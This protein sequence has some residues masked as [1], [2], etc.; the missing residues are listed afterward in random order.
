MPPDKAPGP[1]GFNGVFFKVCWNIIAKYFYELINDFYHK[2]VNLQSINSSFITL[3]S[4]CENL[5]E[6][7]YFRPN[8]LLNCTI[9]IITKLL[10]NR[11]QKV[12]LELVHTN[13]Y[14]FLRSR[15]IQDCLAWAFEYI[16]QCQKLNQDIVI[17]KLDF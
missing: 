16:Y 15:T 3:S 2:N 5:Q 8:S 11:L 13:Q 14:R 17:R 1:D 10:A 4:K 7:S 9:K 6:P 12:I